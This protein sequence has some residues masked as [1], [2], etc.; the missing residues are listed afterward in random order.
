MSV[1]WSQVA[2]EGRRERHE[3][4]K[5]HVWLAWLGILPQVEVMGH[6]GGEWESGEREA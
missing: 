3:S 2:I 5:G 4:L 6:G 1:G